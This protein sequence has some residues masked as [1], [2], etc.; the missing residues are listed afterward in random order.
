MIR[1]HLDKVFTPQDPEETTRML[2]D[3]YA[4]TASGDPA[5]WDG[6]TPTIS[7]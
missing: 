3:V 6:P 4:T 1:E 5:P 2:N 7:C